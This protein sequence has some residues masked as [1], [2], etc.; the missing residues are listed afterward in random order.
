MKGRPTRAALLCV[1]GF[2]L[3]QLTGKP[4]YCVGTID[5]I[6]TLAIQALKRA[7]AISAGRQCQGEICPTIRA[8]RSVC[9]SHAT[10]L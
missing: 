3:A 5:G 8:S 7:R 4:A 9:L 10:I 2:S 6:W 1:G